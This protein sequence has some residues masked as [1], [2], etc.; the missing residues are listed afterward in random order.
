MQWCW[1][2]GSHIFILTVF[3]DWSYFRLFSG[4]YLDMVALSGTQADLTGRKRDKS[5]VILIGYATLYILMASFLHAL[6]LHC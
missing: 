5:W 2:N 3:L 1:G 4:E 6:Y